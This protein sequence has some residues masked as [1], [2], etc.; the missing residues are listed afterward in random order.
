M[1]IESPIEALD[2]ELPEM[3]E[4]PA[5]APEPDT[6]PMDVVA[7]AGGPL[8]DSRQFAVDTDLLALAYAEDGPESSGPQDDLDLLPLN[9]L[10][11]TEPAATQEDAASR[12]A[13][14]HLEADTL[15][16][17]VL[18]CERA[19]E[20]KILALCELQDARA[21]AEPEIPAPRSRAS[22]S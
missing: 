12:Q 21:E 9:E 20:S 11:D 22:K 3:A 14:Y 8:A 5:A 18:A 4:L 10:A 19:D 15:E 17:T 13:Y 1:R 2:L 6:V 7:A 16:D